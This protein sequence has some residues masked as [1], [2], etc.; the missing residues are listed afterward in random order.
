MSSSKSALKILLILSFLLPSA[1]FSQDSISAEA[2]KKVIAQV[3]DL[4][5]APPLFIYNDL[6]LGHEVDDF[7]DVIDA[8]TGVFNPLY[9]PYLK[10]V[11]GDLEEYQYGPQAKAGVVLA[12][13]NNFPAFYN[14]D[15]A[16]YQLL[17]KVEDF[18]SILK[19]L[20]P[21][22]PQI[23][24]FNSGTGLPGYAKILITENRDW[25]KFLIL[26]DD[27]KIGIGQDVLDEALKRIDKRLVEIQELYPPQSIEKY[28]KEAQVGAIN[29]TTR[30]GK[31]EEDQK[32]A[33]ILYYGKD[34]P[35]IDQ[36]I[37]TYANGEEAKPFYLN[38]EAIK[39]DILTATI[40]SKGKAIDWIMVVF[41]DRMTEEYGDSVANGGVFIKLKPQ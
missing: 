4:E 25:S 29:F 37:Q 33:P 7:I 21:Q 31:E 2:F 5:K 15:L 27:E 19:E 18:S 3:Y 9:I 14:A 36:L 6:V 28:G 13:L 23:Q 32:K 26:V 34:I 16:I 20:R 22:Q 35:S 39:S 10:F 11:I 24:I 1:L 41:D 17:N 40:K 12:N 8:E 38:D 30:Q